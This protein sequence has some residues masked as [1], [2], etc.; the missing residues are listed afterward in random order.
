VRVALP[1]RPSGRTITAAALIAAV[2]VAGPLLEAA[3]QDY[4]IVT[5]T[6]ALLLA[7]LAVATN[8]AWG[9]TG[10]FTLG[11]AVFFGLGA[12]SAGL[13]GVNAGV[14]SLVVLEAAA[15]GV[16]LVAGLVIGLFLFSGRRR[17]GPLYVGLVTLALTYAFER[18]ANGWAAVGSGNGISG[19]PIPVLAGSEVQPGLGFFMLALV[20]LLV[21]LGL[22]VAVTRS[23]FGLVMLAVRDDDER[24]EFLGYGRAVVQLVVFAGTAT[25][26]SV[27]GS[28]FALHEGFTST[29]FLGVALSTQVLIYILLGGRGTLVGPVL[30][31]LLLEVGGQRVQE[32]LPSTWPI[33]IGSVL[34]LVI[35]FL[36]GGLMDLPDRLRRRRPPSTTDDSPS[37][38]YVGVTDG[39]PR[40][41]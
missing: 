41:A 17:V 29:T 37:A 24:A 38:T 3:G 8:I 9:F 7:V 30:G 33:V 19:L 25:F 39:D 4:W 14:D 5:L 32:S 12:Y 15:A 40:S 16:G 28:L 10:I 22:G 31:V 18:L 20:V 13:L 35:L 27:A 6:R 2:V 23:Q 21:V 26:A 36:P 1:D 34:L 11:Q